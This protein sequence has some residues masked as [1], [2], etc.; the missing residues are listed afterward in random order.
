MSQ[1]SAETTYTTWSL[2]EEPYWL[3]AVAPGAWQAV[4]V[5][6]GKQII[7]RL[8]YVIKN[9]FGFS[10]ISN[11]K[12]TP[13]LGPWI[14]P[15][16]AKYT[17]TISVQ[18][19][20]LTQLIE[21]LPKVSSYEIICSPEFTNAMAFHWAGFDLQLGYTYRIPDVTDVDHI[22]NNFDGDTRN[23]YRKAANQ[24][25]VSTEP[26]LKTL[27]ICLEKTY[28]RQ[29]LDVSAA[30]AVLER[31]DDVMASRGQRKFYIAYDA[32]DRPHAAN[33]IVYD[34]RHMF[35]IAGGGDPEL[36]NSGADTLL[37]YDAIKDCAQSSRVFDCAG[38]MMRTVEPFVR[39]FGTIQTPKIIAA[40]CNSTVQLAR[41]LKSAKIKK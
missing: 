7:G 39:G 6:N 3:D 13:W 38:S 23:T 35:T 27:K 36:R 16:Q 26:D 22:W 10:Y 32:Q 28:Q 41:M 18:H 20:I 5:C 19:K 1:P 9:K 37:T 15:K 40:K 25:A 12:F 2:F 29:G 31:I 11:P 24:L 34:D 4:E 8:P 30:L 21:G 17:K 14:I 33:Y